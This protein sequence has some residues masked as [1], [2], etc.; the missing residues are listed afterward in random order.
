MSGVPSNNGMNLTT[1]TLRSV[2]AGYA[3]RSAAA[4]A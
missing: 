4:S 2:A 1:A 3:E